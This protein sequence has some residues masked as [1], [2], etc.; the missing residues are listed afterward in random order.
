MPTKV[1]FTKFTNGTREALA[2]NKIS[3]D[4]ETKRLT[5]YSSDDDTF[6]EQ[7]TIPVE[8]DDS[9]SEYGTPADARAV[10]VAINGIKALIG[11]PLVAT[12]ASD[13]TETDRIYVGTITMG[14]VGYLV[15][16]IMPTHTTRMYR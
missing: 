13:M 2:L 15:V 7:T 8:V 10:G 1:K 14:R 5:L 16:N 6:K 9:L 3:Y 12:Q 4:P 11:S